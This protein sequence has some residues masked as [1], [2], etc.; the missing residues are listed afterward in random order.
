MAEKA[1][2]AEVLTSWW[3]GSRVGWRGRERE[4]EREGQGQDVPFKDNQAHL[5]TAHSVL[6][7]LWTD[8]LS[9]APS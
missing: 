5:L 1:G 9:L 7:L 2:K 4:R 8:Q 3:P 6:N